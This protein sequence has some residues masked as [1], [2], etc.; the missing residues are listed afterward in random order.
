MEIKHHVFWR[1]EVRAF[2]IAKQAESLP[3]LLS[4]LRNEGHPPL[5]YL[6]LKSLYLIF[7]QNWVLP[8]ASILIA[9]VAAFL[10]LFFAPFSVLE[11]VLFLAGVFPLF[12]FSVMAR[13]YGISMLLM[14]LFCTTEPICHFFFCR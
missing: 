2:S 6:I 5:W 4:L 9:M 8:L 12:E 3:N 10:W 13:N 14:F 7:H 11:R 1:D